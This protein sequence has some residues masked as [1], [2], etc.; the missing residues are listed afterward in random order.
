M[1]RTLK[2]EFI[3]DVSIAKV[4]GGAERVLH[5]Q[6]TRMAEKGHQVEILTR[7]SPVHDETFA[8]VQGVDEWRYGIKNGNAFS[9]LASSL[10]NS[11]RL[12]VRRMKEVG[13]DCLNFHQ[14]FS[15][16]GCIHSPL[17]RQAFTLYT[18]HSLSF[19]EFATRHS[20]PTCLAGRIRYRLEMMIRRGLERSAIMK[21]DKV[22]TLSRYMQAKLGRVY[23]ITA[24]KICVIPGGVD[25]DKFRPGSVP[26]SLRHRYG[27]D[28]DTFFL[29]T[30]RNLVPRMGLE[31]LI[32]AMKHVVDGVDDVHLVIGGEGPLRKSLEALVG[33]LGLKMNVSF[34]GFI[35]EAALPDFYRMADLF[36]LPTQ[37]L[38]GFGLV[39]LEA[40]ACGVPVLGTPVGGTNEIL[41][42]LDPEL[43]LKDTGENE[44]AKKI[45]E[46]CRLRMSAPQFW[47]NYKRRCRR[48]VEDN[49]SWQRN[50]DRLEGLVQE[51][52]TGA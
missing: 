29:L 19:E 52:C 26:E 23:G 25:L 6:S 9:F 16:F 46:F 24:D 14:P 41:G 32:R 36:V 10:I 39:T 45:V 43:L 48:F 7:R 37:K 30:V 51:H 50:V 28:P 49:Y 38:E 22:V 35:P 47:E 15:S 17:A 42:A 40:L 8:A 18:C 44:M 13:F 20:K 4:I 5:E 31:N 12:F 27:S 33:Q 3:A 21:S 11:R 34:I 2:V 1:N